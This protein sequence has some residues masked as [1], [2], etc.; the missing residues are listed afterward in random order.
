[1]RIRRNTPGR[2]LATLCLAL[3]TPVA[4]G[5][6]MVHGRT[7]PDAAA[8]DMAAASMAAVDMAAASMAAA[9]VAAAHGG[10]A[11]EHGAA[12]DD[13][14]TAPPAG[15]TGHGSGTHHTGDHGGDGDDCPCCDC[16]AACCTAIVPVLADEVASSGMAIV[17][18]RLAW[19]TASGVSPPRP[20][21]D[22]SH[23]TRAPPLL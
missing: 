1:M 15:R 5:S 7:G 20:A 22:P 3:A 18:H 12:S 2:W 21:F 11:A 17:V 9:D 23:P 8:A 19:P 14:A 10:Y 4:S 16:L 13:A 6:W